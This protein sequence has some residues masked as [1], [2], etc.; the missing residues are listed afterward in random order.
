MRVF[1]LGEFAVTFFAPILFVFLFSF[2]A[3]LAGVRLLAL[4]PGPVPEGGW[5]KFPDK[6]S[7]REGISYFSAEAGEDIYL[8]S[9]EAK[10][11]SLPPIFF[12]KGCTLHLCSNAKSPLSNHLE[13]HWMV[14]G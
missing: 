13:M 8:C 1:F 4:V 14:D 3:N 12:A 5:N 11:K 6:N 2:G 9:S 10:I 7:S